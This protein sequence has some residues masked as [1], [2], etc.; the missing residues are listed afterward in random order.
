MLAFRNEITTVTDGEFV[1]PECHRPLEPVGGEEKSQPARK[2]V[3]GFVGVLLFVAIVFVTWLV[4]TQ[5]RLRHSAPP[6]QPVANESA[7]QAAQGS[8]PAQQPQPA[9]TPM[10]AVTPAPVAGEEVPPAAPVAEAAPNLDLR[11]EQNRQV[12]TEVLKRIDLMPTISGENK[13]KLY[14]S[15][16][17]ARQ[18]GR[19]VTIP[20]GKGSTALAAPDVEKLK[21]QIHSQQLQ[22][23]LQDPTCV[24]VILGFADPKGDEKTNLR[25]SDERARNVL[26]ALRDRC[27]VINLMHTV[28]M[29]GST[30]LDAQGLEK[31]RAVE[32]WAV[33]P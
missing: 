8:K 6:P 10:T 2:I 21:E 25:I 23:L 1:C 32:V 33:L 31:N 22:Q 3:S 4:L 7:T 19:I 15:V 24:F 27:G 14:V 30:L 5:A 13:D 17:R 26:H 16:E 9:A 11:A 28:A 29:G 20:F 12:K 18:M